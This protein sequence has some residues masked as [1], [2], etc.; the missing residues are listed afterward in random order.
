MIGAATTEPE[1]T[2]LERFADDLDLAQYL[3]DEWTE[4]AVATIRGRAGMT[5]GRQSCRD[6]GRDI[7]AQRLALVP[8]ADRCTPCQAHRERG[9]KAS[10]GH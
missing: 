6:C 9:A 8:H 1:T 3:I 4:Q 5:Q 7:P 2:Q 10:A